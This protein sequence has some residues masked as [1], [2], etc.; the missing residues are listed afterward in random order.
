MT[1]SG[2]MPREAR[3]ITPLPPSASFIDGGIAAASSTNSWSRNGTRASSPHAMVM[4]STRFTGSSTSMIVVS[5]RSAAS[6]LRL[7]AR[8]CELAVDE[9]RRGVVVAPPTLPEQALQRRP[10]AVHEDGTVRLGGLVARD[11]GERRVPVVAGEHLVGALA[12]LHHLDV[13]RDLLRQQVEGDAVVADHRLAHGGDRTVDAVEQTRRGDVD[14]V[15]VG[16]EV[17]RDL[18]GVLELVAGLAARRLE[19]DAERGEVLLPGL[20]EQ[21]DH[22]RGVDAAGEQHPDGDVGD[23]PALDCGA[24]RA[25]EGLLPVR[26]R[27]SRPWR[28]HA[29]S[30]APSRRCRARCRRARSPGRSRAGAC[31]RRTGSCGARGRSSGRS[32]TTRRRRGRWTCRRRR[33]AVPAPFR[34]ARQDRG[35]GAREPQPAGHG[36]DVERLDAEPVARQDEPAAAVLPD[37]DGEHPDQ[38][39]DERGAPLGVRGDDDLGVGGRGERWPLPCSSSR[40]CR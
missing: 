40:S 8:A 24:E 12:G 9:G 35:Q 20:G 14:A 32:C 29:R 10:A 22:E 27:T 18:V 5:L 15:V 2:T 19:A 37:R 17:P 31:R 16:A 4:L 30:G 1:A 33:A 3:F 39:V 38:V 11:V 6:T 26:A 23:H 13:L 34:V 25:D 28:G 7:R 36:R 21:P